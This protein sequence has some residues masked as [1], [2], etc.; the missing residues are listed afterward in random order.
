VLTV[1]HY[2]CDW[3]NRVADL[4]CHVCFLVFVFTVL[5]NDQKFM[6]SVDQHTEPVFPLLVECF[7]FSDFVTLPSGNYKISIFDFFVIRQQFCS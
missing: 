7:C 4:C 5:L 6:F 2:V 3:C 1:T